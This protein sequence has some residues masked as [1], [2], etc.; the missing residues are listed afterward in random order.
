MLRWVS[1]ELRQLEPAGSF[2]CSAKNLSNI[3]VKLYF[4]IMFFLP[5]W[6]SQIFLWT[7]PATHPVEAAVGDLEEPLLA[8]LTRQFPSR[9]SLA[10]Q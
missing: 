9:Q 8:A 1:V 5:Q 10:Q 6:T 3:R 7:P 4:E 2:S